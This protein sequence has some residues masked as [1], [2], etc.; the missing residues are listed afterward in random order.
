MNAT[1]SIKGYR[2]LH[3]EAT[4]ARRKAKGAYAT[5]AHKAAFLRLLHFGARYLE[6]SEIELLASHPALTASQR[7]D[8]AELAEKMDSSNYMEELWTLSTQ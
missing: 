6:P 1:H 4:R 8:F 2:Q 5:P 3:A 7:K